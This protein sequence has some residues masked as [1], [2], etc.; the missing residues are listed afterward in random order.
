MAPPCCNLPG[1]ILA[2][3]Q[4][5]RM[6]GADKAFL[7]LK[8]RPLIAH[9]LDRLAPQLGRIAISANGD[10][11]RFTPLGLPVLPDPVP[12]FPG[13]LAG[14]LAA[15]NWAD[16]LGA[17]AII[18]AACDTPFLPEDLVTS[19]WVSAGPAGLAIA[20][21]RDK[22]GTTRLHPT[23]GLWPVALRGD[24]SAALTAGQYSVRQFAA[25][26]QH[27]TAIF[28]GTESF[29]NINRPEDLLRARETV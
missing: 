18:S 16:E 21:D 10:L 9:L 1:V 4:A 5:I 23:F 11:S 8:G 28:S 6:G 12:D 15:L 2:G 25:V 26:H 27:G 13:P 3:G 17:D 20:A 7:S 19:L 22:T 24:L 29:F 14:I